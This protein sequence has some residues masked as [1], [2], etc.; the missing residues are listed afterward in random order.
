MSQRALHV[1]LEIHRVRTLQ[2]G[3]ENGKDQ[4]PAAGRDILLRNRPHF[5]SIKRVSDSQPQCFSTAV[6]NPEG[7]H[8]MRH[9]LPVDSRHL[10][11]ELDAEATTHHRLALPI[12][13][14][15]ETESRAQVDP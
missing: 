1:E 3:I 15:G 13:V 5:F 2:I 12:E 6:Y 14:I 8:R 11:G 9:T 4:P 7:H 10:P